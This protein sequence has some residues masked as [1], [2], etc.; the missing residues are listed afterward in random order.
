MKLIQEKVIK[1]LNVLN[2]LLEIPNKLIN[3]RND[4]LLDYECARLN[5][6]KAKDKVLYKT[7]RIN[8]NSY[9]H[10]SSIVKIPLINL[11]RLKILYMRHKKI[12]KH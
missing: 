11:K 10:F 12:M 4:K 2:D 3:K 1:P 7:V 9:F 5:A 6:D 8:K